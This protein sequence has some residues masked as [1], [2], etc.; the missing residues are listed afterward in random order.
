MG[1]H[2]KPKRISVKFS[3]APPEG[4]H[5]ESFGTLPKQS[6]TRVVRVVFLD[7]HHLPTGGCRTR[8]LQSDR[9]RQGQP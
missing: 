8:P 1:I 2:G 7:L 4:D 9:R 5:S 3:V 6:G